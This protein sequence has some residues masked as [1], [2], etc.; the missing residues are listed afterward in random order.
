MDIQQ[1]NNSGS[2]NSTNNNNISI[3]VPY[4]HGLGEKF[5]KTCKTKEYKF[6]SK[7]QTL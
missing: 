5:K 6:T 1:T 7:A 4:I 2:N 3:V